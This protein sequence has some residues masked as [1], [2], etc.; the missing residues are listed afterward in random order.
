MTEYKH[1]HNPRFHNDGKEDWCDICKL[2]AE[3]TVPEYTLKHQLKMF[4]SSES[5]ANERSP[6]STPDF[7]LAD[8]MLKM[9]EATESMLWDRAQWRGET[10]DQVLKYKQARNAALQVSIR[11]ALPA[12]GSEDH[13]TFDRQ[14]EVI[15]LAVI[16]SLEE[17]HL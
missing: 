11:K 13:G 12:Y 17:Q 4:V 9:L 15:A 3:G 16:K 6:A 5:T 7:I 2:T 8:Y 10:V 1:D 14:A